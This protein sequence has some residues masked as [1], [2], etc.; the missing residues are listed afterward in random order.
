MCRYSEK[1]WDNGNVLENL[2][3]NISHECNMFCKY[4]FADHGHFQNNASIMSEKVAKDSIDYWFKHLDK[5]RKY[6]N[7]TFLVENLC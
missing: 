6:T 4:C 3:L 7:I 2:V 1:E 5:S